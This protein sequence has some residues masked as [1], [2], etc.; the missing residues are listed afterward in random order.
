MQRPLC[1]IRNFRITMG[2]A[3]E[4]PLQVANAAATETTIST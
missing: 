3:I 1:P 4:M 2:P